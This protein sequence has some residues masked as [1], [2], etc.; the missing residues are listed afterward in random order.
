MSQSLDEKCVQITGVGRSPVAAIVDRG[1]V[2]KVDFPDRVKLLL[3]HFRVALLTPGPVSD[4]GWNAAAYDG[5]QLIQHQLGAQTALVQTTWRQ[6]STTH[7]GILPRAVSLDFRA[8]L[9]IYRCR[10][11][12]RPASFPHLFRRHLWQCRLGE[13]R[14]D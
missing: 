10:S 12:R 14:F 11:E 7:S 3:D 2:P 6:T 13:C 5:L 9:R 1:R 4:A 8:W